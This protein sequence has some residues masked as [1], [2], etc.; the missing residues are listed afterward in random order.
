MNKISFFF[1]ACLLSLS[2]C[3]TNKEG[4]L[5]VVAANFDATADVDCKVPCCQYPKLIIEFEHKFNTEDF[6]LDKAWKNNINQSFKIVNQ[7]F[8]ISNIGLIK[9]N[10]AIPFIENFDLILKNG[11]EKKFIK[12]FVLVNDLDK[13][14]ALNSFKNSN[15][16]DTIS[17]TMGLDNSFNEINSK[18]ASNVAIL[19]EINGMY[20][21]NLG[22]YYSYKATLLTGQSLSDTLTI[23]I[24]NDI[25]LIKKIGAVESKFGKDISTTLRF[26]Y[27]KLYEGVDF[28]KSK[29]TIESKISENLI[30]FID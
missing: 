15:I 26:R 13:N 17:M 1:A 14:T 18:K 12:N 3:Y 4:C 22:Q 11:S 29:S 25:N 23:S 28:T 10:I 7:K 24:N 20:D 27:D 21:E 19:D 6:S 9:N 30:R 2:S 8:Y 16:I 5:D